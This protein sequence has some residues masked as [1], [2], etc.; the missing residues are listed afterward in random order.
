M[1]DL[2]SAYLRPGSNRGETAP[3]T[4]L[5]APT[6]RSH[7]PIWRRRAG[8]LLRTWREEA[9][10]RTGD[11][12]KLMQWNSDRLNRIERGTYR[13]GEEDVRAL[14][15]HYGVTDEVAISEVVRVGAGAPDNAWWLPY[16]KKI[17][18]V[19]ADALWLYSQ[20]E[21]LTAYHPT[22]PH[23]L[24]QEPDYVRA[25][26]GTVSMEERKKFNDDEFV[27]MRMGM[28]SILFRHDRLK[29]VTIYVPEIALGVRDVFGPDVTRRQLQALL[30]PPH[31]P[32][33]RVLVV[34]TRSVGHT[35]SGGAPAVVTFRHPW[36]DVATVDS[37][38]VVSSIIGS[39]HV[40]TVREWMRP[41]EESALSPDESKTVISD[42]L[43]ICE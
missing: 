4:R 9:G 13:V 6:T 32:D 36:S 34:P 2:P 33:L 27:S 30:S 38:P 42:Y 12:T 3:M 11:V 16:E 1:S 40:E 15:A 25:I 35:L 31:H 23:G 41:V 26:R 7:A 5:G 10:V 43:R 8:E 17:P 14:C 39:S 19:T 18:P 20:A 24:L 28:K 22:L 29:S 37:P 21:T